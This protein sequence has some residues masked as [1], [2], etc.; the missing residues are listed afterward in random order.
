MFGKDENMKNFDYLEALS[1][2]EQIAVKVEDPAT[3]LPEI[4]GCLKESSELVGAC[5]KYL[6]ELRDGWEKPEESL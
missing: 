5:R 6:R 4:E 2:L 3:G 1:R